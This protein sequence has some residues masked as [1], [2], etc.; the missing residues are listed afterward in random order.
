MK[1]DIKAIKQLPD[2][3]TLTPIEVGRIMGYTAAGVIK[4]LKEKR[5]K[6]VRVA[7][8]WYVMGSAVKAQMVSNSITP[9]DLERP[10]CYTK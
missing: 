9:E 6:G 3:S 1:P 10:G 2:D 7:G 8:K 5:M 4:M